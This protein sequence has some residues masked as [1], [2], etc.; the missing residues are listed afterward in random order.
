MPKIGTLKEIVPGELFKGEINTLD[1]SEA[2]EIRKLKKPL[3]DN[4]PTHGIFAWN[5]SG[6]EVP[7]G[8]AW[9]KT[10]S[11]P[12]REGEKFLSLTLTD[13]SFGKPLNVAAFKTDNQKRPIGAA[14]DRDTKYGDSRRKGAV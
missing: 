10:M 2:F 6:A 14:Q 3:N 13:P 12:G 8:S 1:I 7:I 4:A 9:L 5:K 11:K